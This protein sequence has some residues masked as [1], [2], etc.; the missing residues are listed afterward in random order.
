MYIIEFAQGTKRLA[1]GGVLVAGVYV[2]IYRVAK[3]LP[4]PG[5]A[6]PEPRKAKVSELLGERFFQGEDCG[7]LL[8][9]DVRNVS[10]RIPDLPPQRKG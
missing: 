9:A 5:Q 2:S 7:V 10:I 6:T 8:K 1:R 4:P 3:Q